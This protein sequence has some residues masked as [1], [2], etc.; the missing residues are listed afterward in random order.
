MWN[1]P[2]QPLNTC[3]AEPRSAWRIVSAPSS[4]YRPTVKRSSLLA[5]YSLAVAASVISGCGSRGGSPAVDPGPPTIASKDELRQRLE[6]IAAS[7][8]AGSGLGGMPDMIARLENKAALEA[9]LKRLE[10]AGSPEQVKSIAQE[11][12]KKL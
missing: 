10:A 2:D 6:Y 8:M 12:L 9:D 5:M 7:G 4:G 11:M 3:A 1:E